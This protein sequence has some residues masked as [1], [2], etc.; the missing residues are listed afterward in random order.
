M[1]GGNRPFVVSISG[2]ELLEPPEKYRE[3]FAAK[4]ALFFDDIFDPPFL[5]ILRGFV[6]TAEYNREG[7]SGLGFRTTES[8]ARAGGAISLSL[9]RPNLMR[10]VEEVTGCDPL[11]LTTGR[12]QQIEVNPDTELSWHNDMW[13]PNRRIGFTIN[14]SDNAYEGGDFA[15]RRA[16]TEEVLS[17]H[18]HVDYGGALMFDVGY[19]FE[20]RVAPVTAGGPRRTY[21]G[22][23]YKAEN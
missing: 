17:E 3:E 5:E 18:R 20:H 22:W 14:L 12:V 13:E 2:V 11:V 19:N 8:P 15:L 10:W 23:F 9:R 6:R 21:A 16:G 7:V 4:R 1:S